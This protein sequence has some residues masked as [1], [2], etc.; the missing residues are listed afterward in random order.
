MS[1]TN[2]LIAAL[3][4]N[5]MVKAGESFNSIMSDKISSALDDTKVQMAQTMMGA[6]DT[7]ESIEQDNDDIEND[8]L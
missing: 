3:A 1:D 8:E 6:E 4:S 5:D 7:E 2:E